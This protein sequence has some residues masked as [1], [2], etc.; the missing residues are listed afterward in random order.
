MPIASE[1]DV[2]FGSLLI[3]HI[4]G[5]LSYDGGGGS[6][7]AVD[8]AITGSASGAT[9][10]ILTAS[11]GSTGVAGT[12]TL[13]DIQDGPAGPFL[14]NEAVSGSLAMAAD[15]NGEL[16]STPQAFLD[17]DTLAGDFSGSEVGAAVT[18][19]VTTA[20]AEIVDVRV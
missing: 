12:L 10:L 16:V 18:G 7:P 2:D 20:T 4:D 9:A 5:T 3:S 14:D 8:E 11:D 17:Y 13:T 19:T 6:V 15:A 1:W